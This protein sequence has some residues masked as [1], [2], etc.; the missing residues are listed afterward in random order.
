MIEIG[1]NLHRG[2]G[3]EPR[4]LPRKEHDE[5]HDNAETGGQL[6]KLREAEFHAL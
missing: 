5:Q 1:L 4:L 3:G 2:L 6:K